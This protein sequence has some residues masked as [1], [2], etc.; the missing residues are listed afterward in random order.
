MTPDF[1]SM[2]D[3][4]PPIAYIA[5][6]KGLDPY[7]LP[8]TPDHSLVY[9]VGIAFVA[10]TADEPTCTQKLSGTVQNTTFDDPQGTSILQ[11]YYDDVPGVFTHDFPDDPPV[12]EDFTT[13]PN[14]DYIVG[15]RGTRVKELKFGDTVQLVLQNVWAL[16]ILDH[17][18]HLHGHDFYVV[19]R[20]Y[21]N[22]DPAVD[23][24]GFN[25]VD[26]P[27]FNTFAIPTSG[28]VALRFQAKNPGKITP[29]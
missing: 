1:P 5:N 20:N 29:N 14:T 2:V 21:S 22:F 28:W 11:A 18:F 8:E 3:P 12:F 24:A 25:L 13:A 10:C 4:A 9:V 15:S 17:P 23:P 26:P 6:L 7:D 16:G 27:K 19:G